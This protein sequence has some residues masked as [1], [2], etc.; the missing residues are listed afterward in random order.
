VVIYSNNSL[1]TGFSIIPD[2]SLL[3]KDSKPVILSEYDHIASIK[4]C[5][6][7]LEGASNP[8]DTCQRENNG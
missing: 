5:G 6:V 7:L 2:L 8:G 3:L 1:P 4:R